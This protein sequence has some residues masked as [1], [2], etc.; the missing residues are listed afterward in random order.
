MN[1]ICSLA[2]AFIPEGGV[3][4]KA[5]LQL[6]PAAC[7]KSDCGGSVHTQG[8]EKVEPPAREPEAGCRAPGDRRL[9]RHYPCARLAV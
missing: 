6:H 8:Q 1:E 4:Q 7:T 3:I 2:L 9:P 5:L